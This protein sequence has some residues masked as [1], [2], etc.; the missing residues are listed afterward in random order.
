MNIS[1]P[2]VP[3]IARGYRAKDMCPFIVSLRKAGYTGDVALFVDD[4]PPDTLELFYQYR[5]QLQPLPTRYFLRE[6]RYLLRW[7][8]GTLPAKFRQRASIEFSRYYLHLI[9]AR[10]PCYLDFL[11]RTRGIYSH[12][13]F[14]D[15]KDVF[16]QRD[17]FDFEWKASLCSF[18]EP[19]G[20]Y[21]GD[22]T[23][24]F[25]WLREGF[26][27]TEAKK[28]RDKL[29]ICAGVTFAEIDAALDYLQLLCEHL[30]R[31]NARGLVDQGVHNY[32]LHHQLLKSSQVYD[33][34]ESPVLHL[35]LMPPE[36]LMCNEQG[37]LL[38]GSGRPVNV[39]HQYF[40]HPKAM[41]KV[42]ELIKPAA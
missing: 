10:W 9:D 40:S 29:T 26:G 31:I 13:M 39:I 4:L 5:V 17:P 30:I 36:K 38:N 16:F 25:G 35:G 24:T 27:E 15:I 22:N 11:Q 21:I 33:Y 1:R 34:A 41:S 28:L 3:G 6:R 23:P 42:T 7:L 8:V 2:I 14:T 18:Y 37:T 19:P 12:V 32:L 20:A